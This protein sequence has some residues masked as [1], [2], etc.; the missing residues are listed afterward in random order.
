MIHTYS[1]FKKEFGNRPKDIVFEVTRKEVLAEVG[2]LL[3]DELERDSTV[4]TQDKLNRS[5][6][7]F[8]YARIVDLDKWNKVVDSLCNGEMPERSLRE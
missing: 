4:T 3:R 6:I 2:I 7:S 5:D 8:K 1:K